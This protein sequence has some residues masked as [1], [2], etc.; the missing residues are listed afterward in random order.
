MPDSMS[1]FGELIEEAA[2]IT[3]FCLND[4]NRFAK[5]DLDADCALILDDD[6]PCEGADKTHVFSFQGRAQIGVR[7]RPAAAIEDGLL[8]GPK[9][10]LL[11]AV[12]IVGGFE[13]GL[14]SRFDKGGIERILAA[15]A[16][17]AQRTFRAPPA[18]LAAG[19]MLHAGEV[20]LHIGESPAGSAFLRP[21]VEVAGM[22]AH[23]EPCR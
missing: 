4:L 9:A 19:R 18:I 15:A 13:S 2:T 3:S 8:H 1:I 12:V 10:F 21:V 11:G 5:L 14:L 7:G 16:L 17:H 6:A 22:A 20:G 23:I